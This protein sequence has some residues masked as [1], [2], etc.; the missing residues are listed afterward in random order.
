MSARAVPHS[1]VVIDGTVKLKQADDIFCREE[2]GEKV[3][4]DGGEGVKGCGV[5]Q[6]RIGKEQAMYFPFFVDLTQKQVLVVGAGTIAA[7]RIRTLAEFAGQI[8]VCAPEI[9]A[10]VRE[11]SESYSIVLLEKGFAETDLDGADLVLA[12]TD[13]REL[14]HRIARLCRTRG[15]PVNDCSEKELCDFYFPSIVQKD[16][17]V[18]G[19]G[20]SGQDHGLVKRTRIELE[21]FFRT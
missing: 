12:V 1:C 8:R 18:I 5:N 2:S 16:G 20:A 21:E 7:R 4:I 13:D 11:L 10:S 3:S 6:K 19:I 14:N 9:S 15:I 17:I